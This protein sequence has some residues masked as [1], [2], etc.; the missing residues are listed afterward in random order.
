MS[1]KSLALFSLISLL[2]LIA[3]V[4]TAQEALE[5]VI[6]RV[7]RS[8]IR[9]EVDGN[10][11][12]SLGSGFVVDNRGTIVTNCHVLAGAKRAMAFFPNGKQAEIVGTLLID[13]A[14]DIVVGKINTTEAPPI[15]IASSLPRKGE[16]VVALGAPL[17]LAFSATN[18]IVSAIRSAAEMRSDVNRNDID[19]TWIQVDA[20]LSPGNSGGPLINSAGQLVGMSTLASGGGRAQNLNFGISVTDVRNAIKFSVGVVPVP[21][22]SGVGRIRMEEE[23]PSRKPETGSSGGG[24]GLVRQE[25]S[26]EALNKF[27]NLG[28]R[29]YDKLLSGMRG[30]KTR[31]SSELGQ[32]KNGKTFIPPSLG[33]SDS[34]VVK[35]KVPGSKTPVWFF[36]SEETKRSTIERQQQR[37]KKAN[38]LTGSLKGKDD[39]KSVVELLMNFGPALDPKK[40]N[41]IGFA[42]DIIII[43]SFNQ[44]DVLVAWDENPYLYY[45]ESTAGLHPGELLSVPVLVAGTENVEIGKRPSMTASVTVL[46][47]VSEESIRQAVQARLG[48]RTWRSGQHTVEA[49][50]VSIDDDKVVLKKRDGSE[51]QVPRNKINPED[52]AGL[53]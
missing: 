35:A 17:G 33:D 37:I 28:V 50:L 52:I 16:R 12:P 51:I 18:G 53:D 14:R 6:E 21:L 44:H 24:R 32:M 4:A 10:D 34:A 9:I 3:N 22:P 2:S 31:L 7:E 5:D 47:Q 23:G 48:F 29:D 40:N 38:E 13:E 41:T 25:I 39:Q 19:G 15:E 30:E 26:Q 8:V 11:G 49:K 36:D 42:R 1:S 20:P 27:V 46:Q 45:A 43:H